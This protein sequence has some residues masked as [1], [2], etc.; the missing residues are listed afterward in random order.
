MVSV[1]RTTQNTQNVQFDVCT[2]GSQVTIDTDCPAESTL[3]PTYLYSYKASSTE[4]EG[5]V[6]PVPEPSATA[7][8]MLLGVGGFWLKRRRS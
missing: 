3:I 5:F 6:Q 7:G 8:L 1:W 2:N 4:L